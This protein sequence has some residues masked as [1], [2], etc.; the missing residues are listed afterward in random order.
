MAKGLQYRPETQVGEV[1]VDQ[2]QGDAID[3]AQGAQV[4]D[5]LAL[6][7]AKG[8]GNMRAGGAQ[9]RQ[10]LFAG[11]IAAL[12]QQVLAEPRPEH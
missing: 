4:D 11:G 9:H 1:V 12:F 8:L 10:Q 5:V 7:D 2:A 6:I 3:P